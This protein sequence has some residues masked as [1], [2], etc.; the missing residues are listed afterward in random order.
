[1][2]N[3]YKQ[4]LTEMSHA[5]R[6]VKA[7]NSVFLAAEAEWDRND[8][9]NITA[10]ED[11]A[12]GKAAEKETDDAHER[13]RIKEH[14]LDAIIEMVKGLYAFDGALPHIKKMA[15]AMATELKSAS[16]TCSSCKKAI[17]RGDLDI[18]N[19]GHFYCKHCLLTLKNPDNKLGATKGSWDCVVCKSSWPYF[20]H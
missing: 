16:T 13:L 17:T 5:T 1:M 2:S 6:A 20:G 3:I 15:A 8:R 4:F 7:A 19:C 12:I 18:S 9:G 14:A 10:E 11:E